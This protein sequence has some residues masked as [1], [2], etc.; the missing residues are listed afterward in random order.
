[1]STIGDLELYQRG[2]QLRGEILG[3]ERL[4]QALAKE[5]DL[6]EFYHL[7]GHE[8]CYAQVWSRNGI[9]RKDRSLAIVSMLA[10]LGPGSETL[11]VH[12]RGAIRNG[13]SRA[14]LRQILAMVTWYAGVPVGSMAT[15]TI[16]VA[17]NKVPEAEARSSEASISDAAGDLAERGRQIR[18][19]L[20]GEQTPGATSE[21]GAH[22]AHERALDTHYFGVLW[23]NMDLTLKERCFVLLGVMCGSNKMDDAELWIGAALRAGCQREEI[24]EILLSAA[25]YCGELI[26][27]GARRA[28][29]AVLAKS[30]K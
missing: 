13:C 2:A 4:E 15:V 27:A 21:S 14:Q 7:F 23:S 24:E 3:R 22:A 8:C 25:F 26:Y 6:D 28:L 1:M 5:D 30:E 19:K 12:V 18:K 16:R 11:Q 10:A 17:L 29:L 9:T 20:F